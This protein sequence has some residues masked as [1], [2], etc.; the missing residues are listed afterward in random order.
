MNV[1]ITTDRRSVLPADRHIGDLPAD[2]GA[3]GDGGARA[4]AR[5]GLGPVEA[6]DHDHDRARLRLVRRG[7]VPP[8]LPAQDPGRVHL[9][10]PARLTTRY[11]A[12]P[13]AGEPPGAGAPTRR[14]DSQWTPRMH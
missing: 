9:P 11:G 2:A 1:A 13:M 5:G 12:R 6:A 10:L 7:G 3:A 14:R 8:G 4:G